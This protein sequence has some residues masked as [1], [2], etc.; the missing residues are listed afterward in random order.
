MDSTT[1]TTFD[2]AAATLKTSIDQL[3]VDQGSLEKS[4]AALQAAQA[5]VDAKKSTVA[6]DITT[7]QPQFDAL[8]VAAVALGLTVNM[9][10]V[11]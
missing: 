10:P 2:T 7:L 6:G 8:V 11:P 3:S 9:P 4:N 5:D 1:V